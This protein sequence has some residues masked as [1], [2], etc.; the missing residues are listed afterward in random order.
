MH[1]L[2]HHK[3]NKNKMTTTMEKVKDSF[4]FL[5]VEPIIGQPTYDSIRGLHKKLNANAASVHSHL[6]NGKL[7]LLYLTVKP[8]IYNT[9]S[10]VEF[11]PPENPGPT[12]NIPENGTQ[13]QI[14]AAQKL[15]EENRKLFIQYDA[16]DRALKQL[17]IG[18]VDDMFIN[19]LCDIHVGYANVTTLQLLTHLYTTYGKITDA[20]LRKNL[21]LMNE[22]FDVN[23]PVETFFRRIEECVDYASNGQT[24]FSKEQVVSSAFCSIQKSGFFSEDCREWKRMPTVT[25]TWDRFKAHFTR[26]YEDLKESQQTAGT[27]GYAGNAVNNETA[28]AL[29]NLANAA[30]ADRETMAN[31]TATINSLTRQLAD[32]NN[33]LSQ[34]VALTNTLQAEMAALKR[35]KPPPRMTFDKYCWTHGPQCGHTSAQCNKRDAGH[36]EEA[37]N[38]NR[39][40]GR[41]E[42]WKKRR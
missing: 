28:S 26:A 33:K 10:E 25:K 32:T 27:A 12:V 1:H 30:V 13:H 8:E 14:L 24:P 5:S 20:D 38:T 2:P 19:A 29:T 37:T 22:P 42:K 11:V 40:G 7:G 17:L 6:G 4:P 16:C 21:D 23:L 9:L 34:A 41:E 39:M 31:L 18:A 35:N 15:H 3:S 36:K